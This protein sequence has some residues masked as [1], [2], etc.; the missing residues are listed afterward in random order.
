MKIIDLLNKIANGE[1]VPKEIKYNACL[2]AF[3]RQSQ[4]YYCE[5]F[6]NL[7]EY[8]INEHRTGEFLNDKVEIIKDKPF[9]KRVEEIYNRHID[10]IYGEE[11]E[12]ISKDIKWYLIDEQEKEKTKIAQINMNFKII[13]EKMGEIIDYINKEK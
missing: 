7:F 6:G 3:E 4:D 11:D 13:R 10:Y 1:E 2:F 8:L 9:N 12:K 5:E